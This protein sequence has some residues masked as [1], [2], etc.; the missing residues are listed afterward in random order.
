LSR[1]SSQRS[2]RFQQETRIARGLAEMVGVVRGVIADGFLSV[3]EA[4]Q[5][6]LWTRNNPEVAHRWPANILARHLERIVRDGQVD[7]H[8]RK[9]LEAI[10]SEFAENR[11]GLTFPLATDLPV[12]LPEPEVVFEGSTFVFAGDMTFGPHRACEREVVELG[13]SC[14]RSV[15]RRTDYLVIG[16]LAAG[17]WSQEGFGAQV[18][19]VVQL[20]TR[21]ATIAIISE[22]HWVSAL[23]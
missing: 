6:A 4:N 15:T 11:L 16:T 1:S 18:S 12:D 20:R 2:D 19:D 10:L 23:P 14:E 13:G 22:E 8:E 21:G 7:A 5:L 3:D 17:D 9:H